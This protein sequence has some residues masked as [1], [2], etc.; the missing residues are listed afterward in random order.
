MTMISYA[1]NAE[2]V[3]LNRLFAGR[4]DG[5]YIDVGAH[6]P[7]TDSVTKHF[8]DRGWHG[9]N[10][11]P[12]PVCDRLKAERPRD[13]SL[14][15]AASDAAGTATFFHVAEAPCWSTLDAHAADEIIKH[16]GFSVCEESLPVRTLKDV[17]DEFV[18]GPIDFLKID[19]EGA[20][21][22]VIRGADWAKYRPTVLVVEALVPGIEGSTHGDWEPTLLA[23]DYL[24]AFNDG[25]NRYYLRRE[26]E[27]LLPK[28]SYPA[29]VLDNFIRADVFAMRN[30]WARL[31]STVEWQ[32]NR[33]RE[34]VS[35]V[36]R[37]I[38]RERELVG[39]VQRFIDRERELVATVER[40][41]ARERELSGEESRLRTRVCELST[42]LVRQIRWADDLSVECEE[43][44]RVAEAVRLAM[45]PSTLSAIDR[46]HRVADRF[47]RA[48][49]LAKR[50]L[51]RAA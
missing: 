35:T 8:Y 14:R 24:F 6:D 7:V 38:G 31:K 50:V 40:F 15:I 43:Q 25:L 3:L 16:H 4:D 33:E 47:P 42:A 34:L 10:I 1:Q 5:F 17:C 18:R 48:K 13:V 51:R 46:L 11:E 22:A 36:E 19:V 23:A 12:R 49:R 44:Q 2:D 37:F 32:L 29:G 9:I 20:E 26:D 45:S 27:H 28:L 30:E 39:T 41:V 21:G